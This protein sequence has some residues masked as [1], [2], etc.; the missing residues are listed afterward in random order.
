M[1]NTDYHS[2]SEFAVLR[3]C[4]CT[5]TVVAIMQSFVPFIGFGN[6][7]SVDFVATD[8]HQMVASY[9]SA[10]TVIYDLETG[11]AVLNLDS[12]TTYGKGQ[13]SN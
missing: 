9:A 4:F 2:M 6:P 8:L 11:K 7:T 10:R 1:G 13:H 3:T 12:A 5:S